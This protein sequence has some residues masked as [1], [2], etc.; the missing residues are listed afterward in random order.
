MILFAN[1][2][3]ETQSHSIQPCFFLRWMPLSIF[4]F[5]QTAA[6]RLCIFWTW[7]RTNALRNH[8]ILQSFSLFLYLKVLLIKKRPQQGCCFAVFT[9]TR[10]T[11]SS[12][13]ESSVSCWK[14]PTN[15]AV[16]VWKCNCC[17]AKKVIHTLTLWNLCIC[18]KVYLWIYLWKSR[19]NW[20][21]NPGHGS[22]SVGWV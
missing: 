19:E 4:L 5:S 21:I 2:T 14:P 15:M 12:R 1:T 9:W 17:L 20:G 6:A 8:C 3:F 13:E 22:L 10:Q 11:S 16:S 18:G 7:T